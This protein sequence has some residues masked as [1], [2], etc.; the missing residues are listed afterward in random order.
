M[1][2]KNIFNLL[3]FFVAIFVSIIL[4][5]VLLRVLNFDPWILYE[6]DL[7]EPTNNKYDAKIG[8]KPKEGIYIFPPKT[9]DG[10]STTFTILKDG[11]R[12]NGK[13]INDSNEEIVL[14]GGSWVQGVAVDDQETFAWLLQKKLPNFKVK[15]YGVA[16]YGTYQSYLLLEEILKKK[17]NIQ[18]IIYFFMDHH[19]IRNVGDTG[20]LSHITKYSKRDTLYLPYAQLDKNQNLIE[21]KPIKYIALPLREYSALI[22]RIERKIMRIKFFS[23][24]KDKTK[25]TQKIILKMKEISEKNGSEFLFVNLL[26]GKDILAPYVK[27]S[28]ENNILF[29]DCGY[30][31]NIDLVVQN[32]G[33]PNHK[34]HKLYAECIYNLAFN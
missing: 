7:D 14:I 12:F 6:N 31:L 4:L 34:L 11:S 23:L 33:H 8:W 17:N 27:F 32:D 1:L 20:W 30:K 29:I 2:K 16:G 15:N 18:Y 9:A 3:T 28:K 21:Y 26:S 5:E 24:Y 13:P 22:T 10:N 25:I 19:E